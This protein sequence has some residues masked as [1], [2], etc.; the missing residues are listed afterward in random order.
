MCTNYYFKNIM[1]NYKKIKYKSITYEN[2][3]EIKD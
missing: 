2:L 1:S 3:L